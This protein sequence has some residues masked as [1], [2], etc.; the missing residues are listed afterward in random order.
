MACDISLLRL[1]QGLEL[2]L[3]L[4]ALFPQMGVLRFGGVLGQ[5]EDAELGV[6]GVD[7]ARCTA[8]RRPA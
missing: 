5:R 4:G 8:A 3:Q 6:E 7:L 1:Q 2:L